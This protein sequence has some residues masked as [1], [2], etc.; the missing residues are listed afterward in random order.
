MSD[1]ERRRVSGGFRLP[2]GR[3]G[4]VVALPA[5]ARAV[6]G[7]QRWQPCG[8]MAVCRSLQAGG[9]EILWVRSG[10]GS[11]RALR[12]ASWLLAEGVDALGILGVSGGLSP[13]LVPGQ[14][15][16]ADSVADADGKCWPVPA[17]FGER[18]RELLTRAG[19][20][21]R[22]GSVLTSPAPL[23]TATEKAAW[24]QRSGA[25]AVDMESAA[26]ACA[27]N[28]A[29]RPFFALRAICD[30]ASRRVP[31]ELSQWVDGQGRPRL[32][33]LLKDLIRRPALIAD[34]WRMQGDFAC[35][36]R[37][38]EQGWHAL[39]T[40]LTGREEYGEGDKRR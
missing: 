11:E 23:L 13:D 3:L 8:E 10:L 21:V 28:R 2:P 9:R 26:V 33:T 7:R 25:L 34:L 30:S 14:L 12:A 5:E 37:A 31:A 18:L 19:H 40:Y 20:A 1:A 24:F 35:A 27:A 39:A 29:G 36:L 32:P 15:V 16:L 17:D 38:L 4:M 22:Y 6:L